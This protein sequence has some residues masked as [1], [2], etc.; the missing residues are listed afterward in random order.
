MSATPLDRLPPERPARVE[1]V[2]QAD[3]DHPIARAG[4]R[5][6]AVS[7]RTHDLLLIGNGDACDSA[8]PLIAGAISI[9]IDEDRSGDRL[10][11]RRHGCAATSDAAISVR[12]IARLYSRNEGAIGRFIDLSRKPLPTNSSRSAAVMVYTK[13]AHSRNSAGGIF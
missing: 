13:T 2:R 12:R 3:E 6:G 5:V 10:V 1:A 4:E 8:L 7:G 9:R 11:R